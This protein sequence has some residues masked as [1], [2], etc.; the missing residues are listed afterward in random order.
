MKLTPARGNTSHP[1]MRG[2]W[3][4]PQGRAAKAAPGEEGK[5]TEKVESP[6]TPLNHNWKVD[7]LSA[8][9]QIIDT[10][11]VVPLFEC[12]DL[13][14]A[15][16]GTAYVAVTFR[17]G[18]WSPK[19]AGATPTGGGA[20][21]GTKTTGVRLSREGRPRAPHD[22]P[23]RPPVVEDDGQALQNLLLELPARGGEAPRGCR[24]GGGREE[25][26]GT[27]LL[28]TVDGGQDRADVGV[29]FL[30]PL[31]RLGGRGEAPVVDV[32]PGDRDLGPGHSSEFSSA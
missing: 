26:L 29:V 24:D 12:E 11:N 18:N 4:K 9:I 27:R 28:V 32:E 20:G 14:K 1:L 13:E 16:N 19:H 17:V 8:A 6:A 7:N 2:V 5:T 31:P 15:K 3:Q 23:L 30:E 21:G 10:A 22:Q 25:E